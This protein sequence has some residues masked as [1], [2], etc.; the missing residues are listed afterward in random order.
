MQTKPIYFS[1]ILSLAFYGLSYKSFGQVYLDLIDCNQCIWAPRDAKIYQ[2]QMDWQEDFDAEVCFPDDFHSNT[3]GKI[4]VGSDTILKTHLVHNYYR[5]GI[6]YWNGK[7]WKYRFLGSFDGT[8]TG[9]GAANFDFYYVTKYLGIYYIYYF[10]GSWSELIHQTFSIRSADIAVDNLGRAW[11]LIG[12]E[13]QVADHF[14]V[15]DRNGDKVR[16]YPIEQPFSYRNVYGITIEKDIVYLGIGPF[17]EYYQSSILAYK[18]EE[19]KAKL[20]EVM[21]QSD[22]ALSYFDLSSGN[23]G[24]PGRSPDEENPFGIYVYPN[25]TQGPFTVNS[26]IPAKITVSVFDLQGRCVHTET[27]SSGDVLDISKLATGTYLYRASVY[28]EVK[29]GKILKLDD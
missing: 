1:I 21:T 28:G 6:H 22:T 20:V 7:E 25:P 8:I 29:S 16:E 3:I 17:G 4:R 24:V 23:P 14:L 5:S 9:I 13:P 10:N 2:W 15:I 19:S 18:I 27:V 26:A 12:K 11:F